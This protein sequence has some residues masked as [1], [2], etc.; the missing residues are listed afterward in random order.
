M[1]TDKYLFEEPIFLTP[2]SIEAEASMGTIAGYAPLAN[3]GTPYQQFRYPKDIDD[4]FLNPVYDKLSDEEMRKYALEIF[5]DKYKAPIIKEF[6]S[7]DE[8]VLVAHLK[9]KA[10]KAAAKATMTIKKLFKKIDE[11]EKNDPGSLIT[12]RKICHIVFTFIA[13]FGINLLPL[14]FAVRAL[15]IMVTIVTSAQKYADYIKRQKDWFDSESK[16]FEQKIAAAEGDPDKV[17]DLEKAYGEFKRKNAQCE[18]S[19]K[20]LF[21]EKDSSANDRHSSSYY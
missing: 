13:I 1:N 18:R 14:S 19:F 5:N 3:S 2:D 8:S 21:K 9:V 7:Y 20:R 16:W 15:A 4:L 10:K 11:K 17:K 6:S 12:A